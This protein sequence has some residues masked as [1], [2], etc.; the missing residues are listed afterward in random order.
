MQQN[1]KVYTIFHLRQ[2]YQEILLSKYNKP[3]KSNPKLFR[4]HI[5]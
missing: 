5:L 2:I 3:Y 1:I 4:E